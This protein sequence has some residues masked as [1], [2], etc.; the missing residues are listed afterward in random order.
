MFRSLHKLTLT[1]LL[2][3]LTSLFFFQGAD[4]A[5]SATLQ[6]D[7]NSESDLAGYN[8]YRSTSSGSGYSKVNSSLISSPCFTDDSILLGVTYYYVCTA[9]NISGLES[10]HSNEVSYMSGPLNTPPV[11]IS[12]NATTATGTSISVNVLANDSD[13]DGDPLQVTGVFGAAHGSTSFTATSVVYTSVADY[14]GSDSFSYTVSDGQGGTNNAVVTVTVVSSNRAPV[15]VDDAASTTIGRAV[16]IEVLSNDSD[17]DGDP[18]TIKSLGN[19]PHGTLRI[20]SDQ[21]VTYTPKQNYK[22]GTESFNYTVSDGEGATA[23]AKVTVTVGK[24]VNQPPVAVDDSA[25]AQED[26]SV[27][28]NVTANDSDADGDSLTVVSVTQPAHGTRTIEGGSSIR[29]T[30]A[31][32]YF[33]GDSFSYTV[34]DGHGGTASAAVSITVA[35]VNDLPVAVEDSAGVQQNS[36]VAIDVL[37]NDSDPDGDTLSVV[38]VSQP[39]HGSAS[40]E[41]GGTV[42]YTPA[43][44]YTGADTFD[45][46][47][48]D[49]HGGTATA[50]VMVSVAEVDDASPVAVGD[51]A[52]VQED[53][54]VVVNVTA[55]DNDPDGDVLTVVSVTQPAHGTTAIEGTDS[56]RYTPASDYSGSDVFSYTI[57]DGRS[58]TASANVSV[59]VTPVNDLPVAVDDS[60]EVQENSTVLVNV[61]SNDSDVDGDA[62]T[63]LSV[64]ASANGTVSVE[65]SDA[66]RYTPT[67]DCSGSDSFT[68]TVSDGQ[69]GT[70]TAKVTVSVISLVNTPPVASNDTLVTAEDHA[71][72]VDV[73]ANDSDPDTDLLAV[74]SVT[75]PSHG[76]TVIQNSTTI[77]YTPAADYFGSDSF[78]YFV[79]DGRGGSASATVSVTVTPVNDPPV[80]ADDQASVMAGSSILI[81]VLVNDTDVDGD[82]L[83]VSQVGAAQHGQTAVE[84]TDQVRYTPETGFVGTDTFTYQVSDGH[85]SLSAQVTVK[86]TE[87]PSQQTTGLVFPVSVDTGSSQY[88]SNTYVGVGLLN[89]GSTYEYVTVE[90]HS[91]SGSQLSEQHLAKP[92][93]PKGQAAFQTSELSMLM[94]DSISLKV[95]G[96]GGNLK[97]FFMVGDP[98]A[99]RLD[100]VGGQLEVADSLYFPM[101]HECPTESTLI[102]VLNPSTEA[103]AYLTIDLHR[104]DGTLANKTYAVVAP[105]G[106]LM[107]TVTD[108]FGSQGS[109]NEGFIHMTS[110]IPLCGYEVV[111]SQK[112][113]SSGSGRKAAS[114]SRLV[115]PHFFIDPNGGTSSL[116]I[117]NAG[118]QTREATVRVYDDSGEVI[119]EQPVTLGAGQLKLVSASTVF[120]LGNQKPSSLL[121]G[122]VEIDVPGSAPIVASVDFSGF[123]GKSAT[124]IPMVPEGFYETVFAQI[125]QSASRDMFTG[126]AVLNPSNAPVSV[127]VQAYDPDGNLMATKIFELAPQSRRVDTLASPT[128]FGASFDQIQGHLRIHSNGKVVSYAIFGD[129]RGEFLSTIEGQQ[130]TD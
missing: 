76:T 47:I 35:A 12:D 67:T 3:A 27:L 39:S 20:E 118:A 80:A 111:A 102:Q 55:N 29:Y 63:V 52:G 78:S 64:T 15:A 24:A 10:G 106:S 89:P 19:A 129:S 74:D 51:T 100:G 90:S 72:T 116:R 37:S 75:Q 119:V 8:L 62:L 77:L 5:A 23:T 44:D 112:N 1:H 87:P 94:P 68:Y 101:I 130:A 97:G 107:G 65:G 17:P 31:A 26:S 38:S 41:T 86:V 2:F 122:W 28:I 22:G 69:G 115:A 49:S 114:T 82:T 61:T 14:V 32:D 4:Y 121:A 34:S 88:L 48:S 66:V 58:G 70:A 13:P 103:P 33:G 108:I 43:T 6:W 59:S 79:S 54:S 98:N 46:T 85:E 81:P 56:I 50:T 99:R 93:P 117:L 25:G 16:G 110:D 84:G 83:G 42:R 91:S 18:L 124:S 120:G 45:Y 36:N 73:T 127:Q 128:F 9:V 57:S 125:A 126:L 92:L 109:L 105:G 7:P 123:A 21:T 71:E 95:A 53:S 96:D 40:I 11:A 60:T 113:L 104:E 30:P